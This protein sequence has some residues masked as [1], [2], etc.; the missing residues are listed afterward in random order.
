MIDGI[1]SILNMHARG[2][3]P[4][5]EVVPWVVRRLALNDGT[6]PDFQS[7]PDWL[8]EA[9]ITRIQRFEVEGEWFMVGPNMPG[10]EDHGPYAHK[11]RQEILEPLGRLPPLAA[12]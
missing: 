12:R 3:M 1:D 5:S 8:Q 9:V 11:V 4:I 6:Q 10:M 2:D 7:L